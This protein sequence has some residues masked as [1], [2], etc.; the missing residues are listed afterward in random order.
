MS[1]S[2]TT[3]TTSTSY[4]HGFDAL[5][6]EVDAFLNAAKAGRE[7]FK[8]WNVETSLVFQGNAFSFSRVNPFKKA[9]GN[10]KAGSPFMLLT[11]RAALKTQ[12]VEDVCQEAIGAY[13][14]TLKPEQILLESYFE[15]S[16]TSKNGLTWYS[17]RVNLPLMEGRDQARM[18]VT[19]KSHTIKFVLAN[20]ILSGSHGEQ[21]IL[22]EDV[23]T[24]KEDG[25]LLTTLPK[26]AVIVQ[27]Y[28]VLR[29]RSF[30][31]V[32]KTAE[33][34]EQKIF[35]E[36]EML[37]EIAASLASEDAGAAEER[38]ALELGF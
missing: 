34:I 9:T 10:T 19:L 16:P 3:S 35:T 31:K 1:T 11:C 13:L 17:S 5:L 27:E 23:Q 32:R 18:R 7:S 6:D 15:S 33:Q 38:G 30:G 14:M 36:D 4:I 2:T 25:A 21:V 26:G 37:E 24:R 29:V 20:Q 22:P 28:V 8:R 12:V